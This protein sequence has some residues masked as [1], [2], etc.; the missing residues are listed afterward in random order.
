VL[1]SY[2]FIN[3]GLHRQQVDTLADNAAMIR[4][5]SRAGFAEEGRL[6]RSAWVNG[7]FADEVI[8]GMLAS[9]WHGSGAGDGAPGRRA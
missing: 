1:C 4:A 7:E 9:E 2:G 6:R 3:R 5:A 8:L